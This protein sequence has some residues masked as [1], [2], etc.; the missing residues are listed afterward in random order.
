MFFDLID[1]ALVNSRAVYT[2]RDNNISLLNFK[3]VVTK[4]FIGGLVDTVIV[5]DCSPQVDQASK[6]L[7]NHPHAEKSQP[8]CLSFRK[9]HYC[10]NECSD[11]KTFVFCQTCDQYVWLTKERNHFLKHHLYFSFMITYFFQVPF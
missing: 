4:A 11:R 8:I 6:N 5:R 1:I 9:C 3:L 2:K 7:M 10:K